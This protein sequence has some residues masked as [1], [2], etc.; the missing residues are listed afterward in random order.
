MG[1][2]EKFQ[3]ILSILS[4][5]GC[6]KRCMQIASVQVN[7]N[8]RNKIQHFH[9][10]SNG[11]E[12]NQLLHLEPYTPSTGKKNVNGPANLLEQVS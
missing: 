2:G 12:K 6:V 9:L 8:M 7:G 10:P 3:E 5:Q 11:Y 4:N 1:H